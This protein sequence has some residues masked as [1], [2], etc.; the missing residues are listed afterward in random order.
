MAK[1]NI[2]KSFLTDNKSVYNFMSQPGLGLYIPLY[3]RDYSWDTEN[4]IQ[5]LDDIAKGI[6]RIT[7]ERDEKEIRFLGT[8]ITLVEANRNNIYPKDPQAV[9]SRIEKLIDGQQRLS[10]IAILATLIAKQLYEIQKKV[11]ENNEIFPAIS[12]ICSIWTQKLIDIFSFDL[13]RGNPPRKPKII[14]GNKDFWTRDKSVEEAYKSP[15]ANYLGAFIEAHFSEEKNYPKVSREQHGKILYQNIRAME[16]WLKNCIINAHVN[17]TDEFVPAWDILEVFSQEALWDYEREELVEIIKQKDFTTNRTNSYILSELVQLLVV[18]HYLL[19]RCCFTV[20]QPTDEDWAF[21]MF[22]SLNATGTPLTAIETFKPAVVNEVDSNGGGF[23]ESLT[24]QNF[25]KIEDL[26]SDANT[27]QQKSRRTNDYLTSF[28]VAYNGHSISSHFSYQRK[29]LNLCYNSMEGFGNKS[30]FIH[31]LGNYA[32]FYKIWLNYDSYKN[33]PLDSIR[34]SH[35]ADLATMLIQFLKSSSHKMAITVLGSLYS[36]VI[37]GEEN[38]IANFIEATKAVTAFYFLWRAGHSN[39]GLD[40]VYRE[41]F[42]SESIQDWKYKNG[43][44]TDQLKAHFQKAL[45]HKEITDFES[46][47]KRAKIHLNYEEAEI[48]CRFALM[49]TAHNTMQDAQHPGLM[50]CAR[51]G[52]AKYLCLEK[53]NSPYLKTVE[54]IAPQSITPEWDAALYDNFSQAINSLGNLT[55]LPQELNSSAGKKGWKEKYLYYKCIGETD[56][57]KVQE[58]DNYAHSL[59]IQLKDSTIKLLRNS[60]YSDHIKPLLTLTEE[61]VWNKELVDKRTERMLQIIWERISIWLF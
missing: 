39:A 38:S 1:I 32:E 24:E 19:D 58:I 22:Q 25:K 50:K 7:T 43:I 46:W 29:I 53:W 9:P 56:D 3:Q 15:V 5:L 40:N 11:K 47:A 13:N 41:F 17:N 49:I 2:E 28:F 4:I 30:D 23:K 16:N 44:R 61:S 42:K 48:L 54:H 8:I 45:A 57:T 31:F 59:G 35:E 34:S 36:E 55:L 20:I 37:N 10:T 52:C 26:F 60:S 33:T 51:E 6:N 18:C 14:R 12:E 21:D 27:A